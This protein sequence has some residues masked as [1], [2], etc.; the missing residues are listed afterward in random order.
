MAIKHKKLAKPRFFIFSLPFEQSACFAFSF[1]FFLFLCSPISLLIFFFPQLDVIVA[2]V[3]LGRTPA[4]AGHCQAP[5]RPST[6]SLRCPKQP[7]IG[8]LLFFFPP[9]FG[10]FTAPVWP[11]LLQTKQKSSSQKA[12]LLGENPIWSINPSTIAHTTDVG[13]V[14]YL[15]TSFNP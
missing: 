13:K 3:L 2:S 11:P 15:T 5:H 4:N 6:H 12:S 10:P 14:S 8:A 7:H 1:L 9:L